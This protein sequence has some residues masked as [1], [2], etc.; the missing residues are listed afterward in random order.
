MKI[1]KNST[2]SAIATLMICMGGCGAASTPAAQTDNVPT[3]PAT[4][5]SFADQVAQGQELYAK[6]CAECHGAAGQG[7]PGPAV[8]GIAKG[9][10]PLDPPPNAKLRTTQFK[11]VADIGGFVMTNMPPKKAG[12]LSQD[13][14]LAILAFDLKANGIDLPAKLD[15]ATAST[16]TVPR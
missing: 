6:H 1:D 12:S 9:A 15:L 16:L 14:Y 10:L 7:H 3:S 11:T 8:V 4:T 13:E 2:L 5:S